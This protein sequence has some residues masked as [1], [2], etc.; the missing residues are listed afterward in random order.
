MKTPCEIIV[1]NLVPV[2]KRELAKSLVNDF[3]LNQRLTA[4]KL[5]TSEAAVSRYISGKRGA[6]E[7]TDKEILNEIKVSA[8]RIAK[9][10]NSILLKEICRICQL[11]K[12]KEIIEGINIECE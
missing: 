11:L 10:K 4:D 9:E 8:G 5:V 12:S 3:K 7:I 6:L 2:I 1:W